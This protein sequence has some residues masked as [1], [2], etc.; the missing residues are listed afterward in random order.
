MATSSF[1]K[2]FSVKKASSRKFADTLSSREKP[3]KK[4]LGFNSNFKHMYEVS[5][6][7]KGL[8]GK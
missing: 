8:I 5:S 2:K 6:A 1:T 4:Q 3:A 7:L